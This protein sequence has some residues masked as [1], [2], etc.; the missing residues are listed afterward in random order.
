[1]ATKGTCRNKGYI[2]IFFIIFFSKTQ[3]FPD[4]PFCIKKSEPSK[5]EVASKVIIH[6]KNNGIE[7]NN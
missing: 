6:H 4:D 5:N 3:G 7:I 1:M 2:H